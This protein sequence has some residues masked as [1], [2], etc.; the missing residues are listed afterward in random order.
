M[1]NM[2]RGV[3]RT[4]AQ[5]LPV[6][7][8][9]VLL[10]V[11][12]MSVLYAAAF[13]P[14]L[15]LVLFE[16]GS[17]LRYLALVSP[18]LIVLVLLPL[19][20]SFA[21]ALTARYRGTPFSYAEAFNLSLYGEKVSEGFV[22]LL[23]MLKWALPLAAACGTLYYLN[24]GVEGFTL[25]KALIDIGEAVTGVWNGFV[26]FFANLF[27]GAK[28]IVEGGIVEGAFVILG[29]VGV[30]ALL[31]IW[32]VVRNSAYRYIWAEATELD[33]N[34]RFE[35]RRSLRGRRFSQLG[36]ALVNL[37]L[38]LPVIIVLYFMFEPKQTLEQ[39]ILQYLDSLSGEASLAAM[40]IP[41]GKLAFIF[42][43][44]YLPFVPHRRMITAHFATARLRRQMQ[45][46]E[47][48][49]GGPQQSSLLYTDQPAAPTGRKP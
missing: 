23:H 16:K 19:R 14:L 24:N 47:P 41:Y 36:I 45:Q 29:I 26:N 5:S 15:A 6:V 32:G 30:C 48:D 10:Y 33:K 44:C 25:M 39:L 46:T 31:L 28:T 7:Y 17:F 9:A 4:G 40:A 1:Q 18:V 11:L 34:P 8:F 42:F 49:A 3:R 22:Y 13:A 21:Q 20:F 37:A 2:N 43:V 35:T 27:G 12:M 38:L